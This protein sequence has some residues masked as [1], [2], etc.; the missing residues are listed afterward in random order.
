MSH[1]RLLETGLRWRAW[2]GEYVLYHAAAGDTHL[3]GQ[4]AIE[5]LWRLERG[6]ASVA[7]LAECVAGHCDVDQAHGVVAEIL[8]DLEALDL[9]AQQAC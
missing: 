3:L 1:W 2:G 9:V 6:A 8:V 5:I 7:M 4:A